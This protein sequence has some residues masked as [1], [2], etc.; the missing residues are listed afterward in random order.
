MVGNSRSGPGSFSLPAAI[1][2]FACAFTVLAW[3]W[4]SGRVTIPW[5]AKAQFHPQLQFLATSLANGESPFWTPNVFSGWPQIADPQ[6]LIFSPL[7]FLLALATPRPSFWAADAVVF[8]MLFIGGVSLIAYFRD[9]GWH[10]A[11]ALIAALVFCFGGSAAS[12]LQHIGQI[13]SMAYVPL[14]LW[15]LGRTLERASWGCGLVAGIVVGLLVIGRDQVALLGLYLLV[16]FVVAYWFASADIVTRIRRT[17]GPLSLCGIT[18]IAVAVI[19]LLLTGLLASDSNRPAIGIIEAGRGSLHPGH[20]LTLAFADLYGANN[21]NIDFWGVPSIPW[22]NAV[23]PTG[24]YHAQNVGQLYI[25]A[26]PLIAILSFGLVKG[27]LWRADIRFFTIAAAATLLY[28]LGWYTPI[29]RVAYEIM[30]G[31]ALFRRPADATFILGTLLAVLAGYLVHRWVAG[32]VPMARWSQRGMELA[33]ALAVL[34]IAAFLADKIGRMAVA[35]TPLLTGL[36]FAIAGSVVLLG[37]RSM[38]TRRMWTAAALLTAFLVFDLAWNNGP[39]ESTGLPPA[40]YEALRPDTTDE[41]V[42]LL[43][44][45]LAETAAPDRRDRVELIG[46]AY[47]WPNLSLA[48]DFDHLFGHNPLR[49]REFS[50]AT[51]VGDTVASPDQRGFTPLFPS[52]RSAFADLFGLRLI[53]TSVPAEQIDTSIRPGDLK[54]VTRT[55]EAY[56]YE[57]PR[58][59]PRAMLVPEW[60]VTDFEEMQRV[61]WPDVDPKR[62]VLLDRPSHS[63]PQNGVSG[64]SVRIARYTNTEIVIDVESQAGGMLVL[65][66]VWHPWWRA[67][68]D[69]APAEIFKANV[70]FRGVPVQPGRHR[71]RFTFHPVAGAIAE[72]KSKLAAK[73]SSAR[74]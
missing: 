3:P 17:I 62:T 7:H 72:L 71:V 37:A 6:S 30:P 28:A 10:V 63:V 52:Y 39:N 4:L 32:T 15:L 49:L 23:G 20:L 59:L 44:Q 5:D 38:A 68:V 33:L 40:T 47:H 55:S 48:H 1:A 73:L 66:D 35:T 51:G 56:V 34:A 70:L 27:Q 43:K 69:G 16:A 45:K 50:R 24:L 13:M 25:G 26:L 9:R 61:G 8:A 29:F 11:G 14:A 64:G 57:N 41:T 58:A 65:N 42:L 54:L 74:P 36:T 12:R 21:P 18:V 67:E 22:M 53:A 2:V 31:V 46:I 19:P 60:R